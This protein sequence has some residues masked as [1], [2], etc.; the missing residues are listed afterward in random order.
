MEKHKATNKANIK[1]T[2]TKTP[3]VL[4]QNKQEKQHY[5]NSNQQAKLKSATSPKWKKTT[6][7][8]KTHKT[9]K[10]KKITKQKSIEKRSKI[11]KTT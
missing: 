2:T 7:Q 10:T 11:K 4:E 1:K 9:N 3:N 8:N 5:K 6:K